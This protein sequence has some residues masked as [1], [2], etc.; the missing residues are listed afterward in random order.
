M[1]GWIKYVLCIFGIVSS[2]HVVSASINTSDWYGR[3]IYFLMIDRF[4]LDGTDTSTPCAGREWC[5]GTITGIIGKLDYI[6][7]LGFDAIW[8]TPVVEQVEWRDNWD[9]TG[10]HGMRF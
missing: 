2:N 10:Y 4:A 5:G 6:Q 8:I 3:S 1:L 7:D 9:G